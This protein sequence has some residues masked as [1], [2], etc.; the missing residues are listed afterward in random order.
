[1]PIRVLPYDPYW[2]VRFDEERVRLEALLA[3]WLSGGVHH[4]GSTSVPG[5]SAKPIL[6]STPTT[7][8]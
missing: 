2:A 7:S 5:L 3:R 4:I 6:E 8:T 1:M